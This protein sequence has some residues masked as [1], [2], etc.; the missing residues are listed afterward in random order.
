MAESAAGI[1]SRRNGESFHA[2]ILEVPEA[3]LDL[4]WEIL[5][6]VDDVADDDPMFTEG[7]H[8]DVALALE[9]VPRLRFH[10]IG[11]QGDGVPIPRQPP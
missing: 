8:G 7:W 5:D 2:P 1:D 3:S 4:A 9:A 10:L 11:G 6:P